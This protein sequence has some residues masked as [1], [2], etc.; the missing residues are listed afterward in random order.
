MARVRVAPVADF[1]NETGLRIEIEDHRVAMF[2]VGDEIYAIGDRCSHAE[3][4][5]AEGEVFDNEVECP[6]H[7]AAFSLV[8]GHA[9]TLPATNPVPVYKVDVED[10]VVYLMIDEES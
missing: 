2:R 9:L 4:S 10:D 8:D 5:L 7:G 6:R 1:P 3:A